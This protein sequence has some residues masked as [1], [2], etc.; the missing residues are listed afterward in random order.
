MPSHQ[1]CGSY[2]PGHFTHWI[3]A[4][5]SH[6]PDPR[7]IRENHGCTVRQNWLAD[8]D[9]I[10]DADAGEPQSG[11]LAGTRNPAPWLKALLRKGA[12]DFGGSAPYNDAEGC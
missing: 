11:Y 5:K 4:K 10:P 8:L 3:Q 2:G 6:K 1:T 7:A 12:E 9:A